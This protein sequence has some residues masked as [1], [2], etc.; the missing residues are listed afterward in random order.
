MKIKGAWKFW[1]IFGILKEL[2]GI[3]RRIKRVYPELVE[4][5]QAYQEAKQTYLDALSDG[6]LTD[7]ERNNILQANGE[8]GAEVLDV[9]AILLPELEEIQDIYDE[10]VDN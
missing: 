1:K 4:V 8:L 3:V 9:M 5:N 10:L 7:Q 6:S 2:L